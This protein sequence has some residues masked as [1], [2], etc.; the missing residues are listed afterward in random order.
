MLNPG[1]HLLHL[2]DF[3][4]ATTLCWV[5]A[6]LEGCW[7][8]SLLA[9]FYHALANEMQGM[10]HSLPTS[11]LSSEETQLALTGVCREFSEHVGKF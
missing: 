9:W 2:C 5:L 4:Q 8:A 6:G 1:A 3:E 10:F 7:E 11:I